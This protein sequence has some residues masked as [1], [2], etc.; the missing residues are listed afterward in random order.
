MAK[1]T[2]TYT[3]GHTDTIQL[4][5][6][7][8]DREW[9]LAREGEKL[10]PDCYRAKLEAD[11]QKQ[12]SEAA[13]ANRIDGLPELQGSEK[14]VAW[15]E[16][17]R[18]SMIDKFD[19][20]FMSK[21]P[22][23]K[24]AEHPEEYRSVVKGFEALKQHVDA[25]WWIDNRL[26]DDFYG[27]QR[28]VKEEMDK[29][30]QFAA[31]PPVSVI[32][33]AK[34]EATIYPERPISNLVAEISVK[35]D[36]IEVHYHERNDYFRQIMHQCNLKWDGKWVRKVG[37]LNGSIQD[38][39]AEIGNKLLAAGFPVR[40]YDTEIRRRAI[41]GE[42]EEEPKRWIMQ[43]TSGNYTGWF[44]ITWPK[45]GPNYYDA[46]RKLPGSKYDRPNVVVP[47]E[48]F[49]EVLDFASMYKFSFSG[50]A[51]EVV[52]E[53]RKRREL[54]LTTG[55]NIPKS[56]RPPKPGDKPAK[57]EIPEEV[58]IDDEFRDEN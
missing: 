6:P 8:R 18:K 46:A 35:D 52:H 1:Y 55:V 3:C 53:A 13:E 41:S 20:L 21:I 24:K 48:S 39:A 42:Y 4:I 28:L 27:L 12:N 30:K 7:I 33:D 58:T 36:I 15:A 19:K 23:E 14:A 57:L 50:G 54:S 45:D 51:M 10:C 17:I 25:S 9:R 38:R 34:A 49:A 44:V 5:G 40:I 37:K 2:V 26:N 47:P 32:E 43:R 11:R 29:I 22:D 56:E 16:S 31:E